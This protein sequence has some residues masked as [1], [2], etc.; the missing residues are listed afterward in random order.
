MDILLIKVACDLCGSERSSVA[1]KKHGFTAVQCA[2]C[3]LVF[4][5]PRPDAQFLKSEVYNEGYFDAEKGYGIEDLHGR[6][7]VESFRRAAALFDL[8]EKQ[9]RRGAALDVGCAAGFFLEEAARRGWEPHGIEISDYAAAQAREKSGFDILTGDF[10]Q[11]DIP[12]NRFDLILMLDVIEHLTSP[13]KGLQKAYRSLKPGGLLVV[14]TPNYESAPSKVLGVEWGLI[15]PEHHLFYF[16]P[17]TLKRALGRSGLE[18][19][20]LTFPRWGLADLLFSAGSLC[21]AGLPI[22]DK[23]K[24]FVRGRLRGLRDAVRA[25]ADA[26]DKSLLVPVF[27]RAGG[28]TMRAFAKK[29]NPSR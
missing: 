16:T 12:E 9:T 10:V 18:I 4:V 23:E 14:E 1:F 26:A 24:K 28:V 19:A 15:A 6:A 21:R 3:G 13:V 22:G 29:L 2:E 27:G 7:K 25:A 20:S 17:E 8:I 5:N 11:L